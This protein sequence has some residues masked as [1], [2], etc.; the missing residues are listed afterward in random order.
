MSKRANNEGSVYQRASD[1]RWLA[2]WTEPGGKRKVSYHP[3]KKAAQTALRKAL[4]RLDTGLSG[5]DSAMTF[6]SAFE[7]WRRVGLP[8]SA[9][10]AKSARVYVDTAKIHVL[11]VIG[12]RK[13]RD[14]RRSDVATVFTTMADAGLST[15]YQRQ[16][17][18]AISHVL[19]WAI[20][21][22]LLSV[23]VTQGVTPVT[24]ART[25]KAVPT[26]KQV[27]TIV[28]KAPTPRLRAAVGLW[29]F[30]AMRIGESLNLTWD[31]VDLEERTIHVVMGKGQRSRVLPISDPLLVV[32]KAWRSKQAKDRLASVWWSDGPEYVIATEIGT[33]SDEHNVRKEFRTWAPEILPGITPHS[34]RHAA[35][36]TLMEA[37]ANPKV[38]AELLGHA[39][40]RQTLDTYTKVRPNMTREAAQQLGRAI[41]GV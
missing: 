4:G 17:K 10:D 41:G 2:A 31:D 14:L 16:A 32:L 28:A 1:G 40:V 23:N 18:K 9:L 25:A 39:S 13:L 19:G 21:E 5:L 37:G 6:R 35:A 24:V 8:V 33:R 29:A 38:V 26:A 11:P 3:T 27:Q 34:M 20:A 36:T 7:T 12:S 22:G 15:A 30:T